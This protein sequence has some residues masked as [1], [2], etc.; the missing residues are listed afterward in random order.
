MDAYVGCHVGTNLLTSHT[1]CTSIKC[2]SSCEIGS[3]SIPCTL[4]LLR[5][6]FFKLRI[7]DL[8]NTM[9]QTRSKDLLNYDRLL[10]LALFS[11]GGV[12]LASRYG[13]IVLE[14]TVDARL[15]VIFRGKFP[16]I[17]QLLFAQS[18]A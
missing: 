13:K 10:A 5:L 12:L 16:E 11:F 18:A 8:V 4:M 3:L 6:M 15:D 17:H 14:N 2:Y 9:R 1:P 7:E